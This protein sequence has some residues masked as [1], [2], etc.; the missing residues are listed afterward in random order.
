MYPAETIPPW[1]NAADP[2]D[3]KPAVQRIK[4]RH[5]GTDKMTWADWQPFVSAYFG[6]VSLIDSQAGRVIEHLRK[7]GLLENTVIVWSTDH[8]DT[9]GAHGICNKDYTMYHEIYRVPLIVRWPGVTRPGSSSSNFVH[10]FMDLCATFLD[11]VGQ[12]VPATLQGGVSFRSC[13]AIRSA[14]GRPKPIANSTAA[15]SAC[16]RCGCSRT[17]DSATSITRTISTSSTTT[18]PIRTR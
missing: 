16:T 18:K 2:L 1:P 15:I 5:Y 17:N 7:N 6:E 10:H 14:N 12:P 8:G 11:I 13:A 4:K 9:I 3:T